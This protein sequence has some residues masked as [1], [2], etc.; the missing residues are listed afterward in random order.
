M[1]SAM[2]PTEYAIPP[3][4][5]K[6]RPMVKACPVGESGPISRNPTVATV[7]TVM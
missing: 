2:T 3:T 4:P 7:I 1:N 6:I 5:A